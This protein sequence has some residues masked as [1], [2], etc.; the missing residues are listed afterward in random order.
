ME[1]IKTEEL[2]IKPNESEAVFTQPGEFFGTL[3]QSVIVIW[4]AHLATS[5]YSEHMA[6]NDFYEDMLDKVDAIIENYQGLHGKVNKYKNKITTFVDTL[7]Y[8]ETLRDYTRKG[9]ELFCDADELESLCDDIMTLINS[10]IYKV[11]ELK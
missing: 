9:R 11:R 5:S 8:L 4:R 6:L 10:T 7:S 2:E 3:Q 1:E